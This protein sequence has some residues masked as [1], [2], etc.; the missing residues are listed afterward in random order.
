MIAS[1]SQTICC[2]CFLDLFF[3]KIVPPVQTTYGLLD[4]KYFEFSNNKF[5]GFSRDFS[6]M[7]LYQMTFFTAV[8]DAFI[9]LN[10]FG[11]RLE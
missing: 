5:Q 7:T 11:T 10:L 3:M 9:S 4:E 1:I 6:F 2:R 8:P